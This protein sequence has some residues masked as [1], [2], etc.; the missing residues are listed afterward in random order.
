MNAASI[1]RS[2]RAARQLSQRELGRRAGV[3]QSTVG[4]I[5]TGAIDPRV[6]TLERLLDALGFD[7]TVEP[8]HG[9]GIDRSLIRGFLRLAPIERIEYAAAAGVA[10]EEL[11]QAARR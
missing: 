7:L 4:R 11:V 8:R 2:A 6:E 3:P 9:D 1:I 5:E 10:V